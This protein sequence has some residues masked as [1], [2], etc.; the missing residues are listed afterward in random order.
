[1]SEDPKKP[2][3]EPVPRYIYYGILLLGNCVLIGTLVL[4]IILADRQPHP[5]SQ[6]WKLVLANVFGGRAAN[7]AIGLDPALNFNRGF[8]LFQVVIIDFIV[9]VIAY[10]LFI[11]NFH[12]LASLPLVGR[13]LV[14]AHE[15]AMRHKDRV[16]KYGAPG[17]LIFVV[18]PLW[19]TGPLVGAIVGFI[20]GLP[21]W[22]TFTVVTI[23]NTVTTVVWIWFFHFVTSFGQELGWYMLMAVLVLAV[24]M[25]LYR[26]VAGWWRRRQLRKVEAAARA[27]EREL[28]TAGHLDVSSLNKLNLRDVPGATRAGIAP[29]DEDGP[30]LLPEPVTPAPGKT[31]HRLRHTIR[32]VREQRRTEGAGRQRAHRPP[33]RRPPKR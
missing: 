30:K 33:R 5:Y 8:L 11:G 25:T 20:L 19:S 13:P 1:M 18:F 21:T 3:V 16:A 27:R 22:L 14:S 10:G 31:L 29:T 12:R 15:M 2:A 6:T 7:C 24:G 32:Q 26:N 9:M 23:G 4:F 17:L 28:A